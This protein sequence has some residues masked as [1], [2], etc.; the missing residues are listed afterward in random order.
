MLE[1]EQIPEH[2]SAE[3]LIVAEAKA[4]G[5]VPWPQEA[6]AEVGS[7]YKLGISAR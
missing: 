2:Q 7:S 5:W 6:C 4:E 1:G 3:G